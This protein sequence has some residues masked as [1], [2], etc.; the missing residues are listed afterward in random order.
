M[1][2]ARNQPILQSDLDTL[3][4]AANTALSPGTSYTF[5]DGTN[6]WREEL[7]RI[8]SDAL[9]KFAGDEDLLVSGPWVVGVNDANT[10]PAPH[11]TVA[12]PYTTVAVDLTNNFTAPAVGAQGELYAGIGVFK[13]VHYRSDALGNIVVSGGRRLISS[14]PVG[15]SSS[16]LS[17]TFNYSATGAGTWNLWLSTIFYGPAGVPPSPGSFAITDTSTIPLSWQTKATATAGQFLLIGTLSSANLTASASGQVAFSATAPAG[18][19]F[20]G[21]IN[22]YGGAIPLN[23]LNVWSQI[24]YSVMS[25]KNSA[26]GLGLNP[27]W[28]ITAEDVPSS[29]SFAFTATDALGNDLNLSHEIFWRISDPTVKGV[30]IANTLPVP[31]VNYFIDQDLPNCLG[32]LA[33]DAVHGFAF[34]GVAVSPS[35]PNLASSLDNAPGA[36]NASGPAQLSNGTPLLRSSLHQQG[37]LQD[38]WSYPFPFWSATTTYNLGASVVDLSGN[39][40][41]SLQNGNLN[42]PPAAGAWW[43]SG[44]AATKSPKYNLIASVGGSR[45][46]A[47]P[48]KRAGDFV[49]WNLGFNLNDAEATF[50]NLTAAS[51]GTVFAT[52]MSSAGS[53]VAKMYIRLVAANSAKI[54]WTNGSFGY[55]TPLAN[56]LLIFVRNFGITK[57]FNPADPTT[58][59]FV[60]STNAVTIPTDGGIGYLAKIKAT[61]T[62]VGAFTIYIATGINRGAYDATKTYRYLDIASDPITGTLY[63][64]I[65]LVPSA[66]VPLSDAAVWV[67]SQPISFDLITR[68]DTSETPARQF[69]AVANECWSYCLDGTAWAASPATGT[70]YCKPIPKS[71]YCLAHV[72]ARRRPVQG[73][74]GYAANYSVTPASGPEITVTLGQNQIQTDG[75]LLF[76]PF[77]GSQSVIGAGGGGG[78]GDSG[79]AFGGAG[80]LSIGLINLVIPA[81]AGEAEMEVFLPVLG[82]G[83]GCLELGFNANGDV[84]VEAWANWQPIWFAGIYGTYWTGDAGS[85]LASFEPTTF[86]HLLGFQNWFNPQFSNDA[87]PGYNVQFA[88]SADNYNDL[89][90]FLEAL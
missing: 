27:V 74:A 40:W 65:N 11:F 68:Q 20:P 87:T 45:P 10:F 64:Y 50:P 24:I 34:G 13:S 33:M 46:A 15:T 66:G 63:K 23:Y 80:G 25:E 56:N 4:A 67:L 77:G 32:V 36:S 39:Q 3:A 18:Y 22:A 6:D 51:D 44:G 86:T 21:E 30:W 85:A 37:L 76:A 79:G 61:E 88:P 52:P 60:T 49:P 16:S 35:L 41:V 8:F 82:N 17:A 53:A 58:Y 71:G 1:A 29:T 69:F 12:L 28:E 55:G 78:A 72:R 54:G 48:V 81:N 14:W 73:L 83:T 59:D 26:L 75:T 90:A 62:P 57:P 31:A 84:L 70:T 19:D 7:D 38:G 47:W 42:H 43:I 2:I 9:A 89:M 5:D